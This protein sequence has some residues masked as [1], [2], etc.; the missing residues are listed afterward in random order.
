MLTENAYFFVF[1]YYFILTYIY[2]YAIFK[3]VKEVLLIRLCGIIYIVYDA[4]E[5]QTMKK[6]FV[7][8]EKRYKQIEIEVGCM[9][10][11][12]TVFFLIPEAEEIRYTSYLKDCLYGCHFTIEEILE[13]SKENNMDLFYMCTM[14]DDRVESEI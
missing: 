7:L 14:Y 1:F 8:N 4:G 5:R 11:E 2:A 12:K 9:A 10:Q 13:D 6:I 3:T